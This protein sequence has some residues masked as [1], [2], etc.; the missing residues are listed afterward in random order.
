MIKRLEKIYDHIFID[1]TQDLAGYDFD[2]LELLLESKI[3][4]TLVGDPRQ[5]TYFTNNSPKYKKFK[6]KNI[7]DLFKLWESDGKCAI[8]YR[9]KCF[10]CNSKICDFADLLY[11]DM[12]PT[13]SYNTDK[14]GHDGI[15]VIRQNELGRYISDYKPAIL[16][17]DK[18]TNTEGQWSMNFGL[19]KGLT[20]DRV[21]IFPNG[22]IKKFLK[23]KNIK[24]VEDSKAKF[25]VALTRAKYSVTFVFDELTPFDCIKCAY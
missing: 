12:P 6:G 4:V 20:F 5:A 25:Y 13:K 16:K 8:E 10:R 21:L 1:E 19:S 7:I 14:T 9:N 24:H 18:R 11:P 3:K 22:P 23:D 15:F 2:L 17:Y